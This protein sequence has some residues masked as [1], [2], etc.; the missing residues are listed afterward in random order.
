MAVKESPLGA[1][2]TERGYFAG[3]SAA[4]ESAFDRN[5]GFTELLSTLYTRPASGDNAQY[6]PREGSKLPS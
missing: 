4:P 3:N 5:G 1:K 2:A 6:F